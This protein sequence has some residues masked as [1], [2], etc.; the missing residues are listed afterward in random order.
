MLGARPEVFNHNIETVRR[1]HRRMRGA[2]ASYDKALWL[3]GRAKE[4][5]DYPVL[6]KSGIIV[7][8]GET[9]DE[10]VETM[11]DL[12]AHGV[13][14]V[15]IGQYL[16]PSREA[17]GDRPLG[18][19]GRVPLAP[20]AGRGAR[21]RLGLRR[22]ARPLELP[23][24]RATPR[25]RD[26]PRRRRVLASAVRLETPHLRGVLARKAWLD[27]VKEEEFARRSRRC[28][29][30]CAGT[31][32]MGCRATACRA[33]ASQATACVTGAP[34]DRPRGGRRTRLRVS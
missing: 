5:A 18:A 6:T 26:R 3:L 4:L 21:L 30:T 1:L 28:S 15:T 8:L 10:V 16:Q 34:L 29:C 14:V 17:R 7:G 22:A 2:K 11:R 20:R 12:R 32:C 13:D 24:R 27:A 25:R 19:P 9:N 31:P 23:R 33:T